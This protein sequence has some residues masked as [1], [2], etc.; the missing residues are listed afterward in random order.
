MLLLELMRKDVTLQEGKLVVWI[1]TLC[2]HDDVQIPTWF[3]ILNIASSCSPL[4][5]SIAVSNFISKVNDSQ[6]VYSLLTQLACTRSEGKS[7]YNAIQESIG[8]CYQKIENCLGRVPCDCVL[9]FMDLL[10][11]LLKDDNAALMESY[12]ELDDSIIDIIKG[13][14]SSCRW[15]ENESD[16]R[17][18]F[19]IHYQRWQHIN[20]LTVCFCSHIIDAKFVILCSKIILHVQYWTRFFRRGIY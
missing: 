5:F 1:V 17:Q 3:I 19:S 11:E 12:T 13:T 6:D 18:T 4:P 14:E 2:R 16:G 10:D 8:Y 20:N 9:T 15:V 7:C